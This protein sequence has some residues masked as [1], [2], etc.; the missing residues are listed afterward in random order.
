MKRHAILCAL[1]MLAAA[2]PLLAAGTAPV[3]PKGLQAIT[4]PS[5][6]VTVSFVRPGQIVQML[7]SKGDEVKE[8][9][10][11]AQQDDSEEQA[12]LARDKRIAEDD[13]EIKAEEVIHDKKVHDVETMKLFSGSQMEIDNAILDEKVEAARIQI[14]KVKR[15]DA[16]LK[17][18]ET[19]AVV[20]KLRIVAPI[21]GIVAEE[22]L[23]AGECAE[24]GN[25]KAVRIVQLDPLWA[26]VPVP[27]LQ[28]RKLNKGDP[29]LVTFSDGKERAGN[30]VVVSPTGDPASETI[31]VRVAIPNPEKIPSGENVFVNFPS[32]AV[33]GAR[34]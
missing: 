26:E 31:L 28:A 22:Y 13:T 3:K 2:I 8:G 1:A 21:S 30:V 18:A 11:I 4:K 9:Q 14:A 7:L 24:A 12:A 16:L 6:D 17:V 25:T 15:E 20:K 19:S 23:K 27:F 33:A 32:P 29:A 34:P 10:L 5:K